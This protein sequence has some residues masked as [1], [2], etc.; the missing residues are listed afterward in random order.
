MNSKRTFLRAGGALMLGA[1]MLLTMPAALADAFTAP[2]PELRLPAGVLRGQDGGDVARYLGIPFAQPPVGAL[3]FKAPQ[4]LP[5]W[6][7]VLDAKAFPAAPIQ[8]PIGPSKYVPVGPTY[9]EDCLY[10]NVWTPKTPGPHP[11][12]V[13]IYGGGNVAGTTSMPVFDGANLAR[14]G[15]VVV[16]V[17]YR[18]G[19]FG[20]MDVSGVLG[21]QYAGS[22]NNGLLDQVMG[23][24]WI[25]KNIGALG[26]DPG[27][28]T[29]GGQSAGAKNVISLIAMPAAKGLFHRVISQS[30]GGQTLATPAMA[31]AVTDGILQRMGLDKS[32][33]SEL[34]TL[35]AKDLLAA[36]V[37]LIAE[38]GYKYPF[39]GVVDG[40]TMPM[41]PV[42]AIAKGA[43]RDI[44]IIMGTARDENAFF[45]PAKTMNG[46]IEA[47]ELANIELPAFDRIFAK[48]PASFPKLNDAQLRYKALTAAEYW[49]PTIR[50]A[51]A[52][53]KAGGK[54][55]V[56]RLDMPFGSGEK[57]GYSVHG[58]ELALVFDN[59]HDS[60]AP[61]LGAT[62][63]E[64]AELGKH[65]LA[66]WVSFVKDGKPVAQGAP[67]WPAYDLAKRPNMVF[68]AKDKLRVQPDLDAVERKL[69]AGW[70]PR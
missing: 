68:D 9:S 51:E 10:L 24:E 23:L 12:Y 7:G 56:Y 28:V 17:A 25:R 39:R 29:I 48:Y 3:R 13:Y 8:M 35:P 67:A 19:V 33:A 2:T 47:R 52:Q 58:S 21:S 36:Q 66:A 65:M 30:G 44:P 16:S 63:P 43:A 54:A 34:T 5:A 6:S 49:V 60:T 37:K 22:G 15:V 45:G 41:L 32:R 50:M 18:V 26:G 27:R 31:A 46:N 20:F 40:V 69:W 38:Y 4:P 70:S 61:A 59:L 14:Q 64:A 11:V 62:G 57:V 42:E 55:Y 1:G 53:A